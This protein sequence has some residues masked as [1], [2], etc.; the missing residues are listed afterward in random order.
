MNREEMVVVYLPMRYLVNNKK[1]LYA[2]RIRELGLTAY[3]STKDEAAQKIKR[4]F[5]AY[6]AVHRKRGILQEKL[7]KSKLRW[8]WLKDW[9]GDVEFV[10]PEGA[11]KILHCKT[12]RETNWVDTGELAL[13]V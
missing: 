9:E 11:S 12:K 4:M 5:A 3:G 1:D 7:D 8:S 13:A 2:T 6:V 10:S